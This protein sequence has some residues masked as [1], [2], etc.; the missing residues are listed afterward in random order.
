MTQDEKVIPTLYPRVQKIAKVGPKFVSF[1]F[2]S[3]LQNISMNK[4]N[5]RMYFAIVLVI[6]TILISSHKPKIFCTFSEKRTVQYTV[7]DFP[8]R[9]KLSDKSQ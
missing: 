2:Q 5:C 4:I 1:I 6:H 8:Q 7:S 9:R 3:Q